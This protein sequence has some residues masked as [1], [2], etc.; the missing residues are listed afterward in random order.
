M[1]TEILGNITETTC[2]VMVNASNGVGYMGGKRC[3]NML[4]RGVAE[5]MQF[6][7]HGK[8]EIASRRSV[9]ERS[10]L[11]SIIGIA[12]GDYFVTESCGLPCTYVFHAVTMR[13]PGSRSKVSWV[14]QCL[15]NLKSFCEEHALYDVALPY[16]GCGN[17][18]V[19]KEI[20]AE[21]V[22]ATFIESFWDIKLVDYVNH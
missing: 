17:G 6:A 22:N 16:I 3:T 10:W 20:L 14:K 11:R 21:L 13:F 7:T 15:L 18:A 4:C 19:P 9:K 5:T 8:I 2:L 1:I 12:P